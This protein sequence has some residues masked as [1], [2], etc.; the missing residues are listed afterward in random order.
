MYYVL[1]AILYAATKSNVSL[2]KNVKLHQKC[3]IS[4]R[5][6]GQVR[7]GN[8]VTIFPF[9]R[10]ETWGGQ[11]RLGNNVTVNPF[12]ILYGHGGLEIGDDVSIAAHSILITAN[13]NFDR[14]D[15]PI[16]LQGET[17]LGIK[18]NDDVWIGA[19][20]VVLDG[21]TIGKGCVIGAGSVVTK[22]VPDFSIAAGNPAKI[23]KKRRNDSNIV[24]NEN[25]V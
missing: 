15:I 25:Q 6:G 21:V 1:K 11:I 20:V 8:N 13:H 2:G 7:L 16:N 12:T 24:N 4:T 5:Y 18:I 14:S 3:Q 10:L 9:A 23:I 17:R 19:N 22:S